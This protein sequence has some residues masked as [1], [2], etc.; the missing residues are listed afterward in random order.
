MKSLEIN[1]F[2][3]LNLLIRITTQQ[4]KNKGKIIIE[5]KRD[6]STSVFSYVLIIREALIGK[7]PNANG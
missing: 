4:I 7:C 2:F 5:F 6:N 1:F 3:F